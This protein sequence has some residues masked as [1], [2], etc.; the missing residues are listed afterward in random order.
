MFV[1]LR[2]LVFNYSFILHWEELRMCGRHGGKGKEEV[3]GFF[4]SFI[5]H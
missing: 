1:F 3:G 5:D 2:F 4:S